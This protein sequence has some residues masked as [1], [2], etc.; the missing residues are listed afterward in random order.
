MGVGMCGRWAWAWL[1]DWLA[2]W[3][4]VGVHLMNEH[5]YAFPC[6]RMMGKEWG[7]GGEGEGKKG[8]GGRWGG[9]GT[10]A[11]DSVSL[12]SSLLS[13]ARSLSAGCGLR[14]R[15]LGVGGGGPGP[16]WMDWILGK[17]LQLLYV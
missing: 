5:G 14:R 10:R 16:G 7:E 2:G 4:P 8:S 3:K 13:C 9:W 15:D 1:A 6:R 17:R 12:L 11:R